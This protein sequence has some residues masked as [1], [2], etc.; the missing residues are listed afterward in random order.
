MGFLKLSYIS[1]TGNSIEVLCPR[2]KGL[3]TIDISTKGLTRINEGFEI[4]SS[5]GTAC[6]SCHTEYFQITSNQDEIKSNQE[7]V[8]K[9]LKPSK[10]SYSTSSTNNGCGMI[11][12]TILLLIGSI[13][14]LV[15]NNHVK[16]ENKTALEKYY[17]THP[18]EYRKDM[19]DQA[20][21]EKVKAELKAQEDKKNLYK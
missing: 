5:I 4:Q 11:I 20:F 19:N 17:E 21:I 7:F 8:E 12:F 9:P 2:C 1:E 14:Y 18:E 3:F 10:R 16:E 15:Y 13:T 6:P